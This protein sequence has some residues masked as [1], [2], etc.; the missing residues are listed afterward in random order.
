MCLALLRGRLEIVFSLL[1]FKR[2]IFLLLLVTVF[3]LARYFKKYNPFVSQNLIFPDTPITD[4]LQHQP[5]TFRI[6]RQYGPVLPPNT[7]TYYRLEAIEGYDPLRLLSYNRL[8]HLAEDSPYFSKASRYSE[9]IHLNPKFLDLLNVKYFVA[10][11]GPPTPEIQALINYGYKPVFADKQTLV[12]ENPKF[13]QRAFFINRLTVVPDE[14]SLAHRLE[15]PDFIPTEEAVVISQASPTSEFSTA[16]Q[17]TDIAERPNGLTLSLNTPKEA[18]LLIS[19][20]YDTGWKAAI[21][22]RD[23]PVIPTDG[24]L[25]GLL[26]P[27]GSHRITLNYLPESITIGSIVSLLSLG[28]TAVFLKTIKV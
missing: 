16:G 11:D 26:I 19:N 18:F 9:L 8:F 2:L 5:G 6:A 12:Y 24:A 25:Q 15:S 22:N 14:T 21:D 3:D 17:I 1:C 7:W 27:A 13:A 20:S 23:A 28:A 10:V 4:F